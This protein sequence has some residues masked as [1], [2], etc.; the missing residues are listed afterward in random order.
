MPTND[1]FQ[2]LIDNT[3]TEVTSINGVKGMKFTSMHNGNYIFFPF[4]GY[5]NSN[6]IC[7]IGSWFSCWA[8]KLNSKDLNYNCA[9]ALYGNNNGYM[10]LYGSYYRTSGRSVRGIYVEDENDGFRKEI[11]KIIK[12][13]YS[14]SLTF[15]ENFENVLYLSLCEDALDG[16][17]LKLLKSIIHDELEKHILTNYSFDFKGLV[18][19]L[20]S[21]LIGKNIVN[22][23]ETDGDYIISV[24]KIKSIETDGTKDGTVIK[25]MEVIS[26]FLS[27]GDDNLY[28]KAS[29]FYEKD[30]Q[31]NLYSVFDD[32]E[33]NKVKNCY[34]IISSNIL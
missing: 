7:Y 25:V 15:R 20:N 30:A 10:G 31:I 32:L 9:W 5:V 29:F 19:K 33:C 23:T 2:E 16:C 22:I 17:K 18:E 21:Y 14:R 8:S 11:S 34:H 26:S 3:T 12:E 1:D 4:A 27:D 13:E 28:N 24:N 6:S